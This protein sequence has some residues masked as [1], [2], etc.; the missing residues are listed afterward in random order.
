M[1]FSRL[2]KDELLEMA[3][4]RCK[5][6]HSFLAHPKCY[7]QAP[8][9]QE[10][11]G[12]FDIE[13]SNLHANFGVLLSYSIKE[14]DGPVLKRVIKPEELRSKKQDYNVTKECIRDILKFDAVVV[15][16]GK[17]R[18]HDLP[19]L[20]TRALV[21]NLEF[22]GY[23]EL[24]I[25]DVYD[26]VKGKLSLHRNRLQNACETLKIP[27]KKHPL[28]GDMWVFALTGDQKALNYILKHNVEDVVSLE[29]LYKKLIKFVRKTNSSI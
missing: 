26:Y 3:K 8:G 16:Y 9:K 18:R 12:F 1:N 23:K 27:A 22:P 25:V 15:Y 5:H 2:S 7:L 28:N 13:T 20:R 19:Y 10:K 29:A 6:G 4:D 21:H 11:I 17:D 14:L 24:A